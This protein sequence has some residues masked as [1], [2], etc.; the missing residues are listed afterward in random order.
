M[1]A[2]GPITRLAFS[3]LK[4]RHEPAAIILQALGWRNPTHLVHC[5]LH[6]TALSLGPVPSDPRA[7][8][9]VLEAKAALAQSE[10]AFALAQEMGRWPADL[11]ARAAIAL[12]RL[13]LSVP[14]DVAG[15]L[16]DN[17][18]LAT[19]L[20]IGEMPPGSTPE[21][22]DGDSAFLTAA[23]SA[24]RGDHRA[25]RRAC[26]AGFAAF[27]LRPMVDEESCAPLGLASF[28]A[29]RSSLT[30]DGPLVSVIVAARDAAATVAPA[31]KSLLRQ[32]W[33]NLEVV[34]V[35]DCSTD[36]TIGCAREAAACDPRLTIARLAAPSGPYAARN[37]GM[38][39]ARGAFISFSD[40]DDVAHADRIALQVA[41]L[42]DGGKSASVSR[43]VRLDECGRPVA[44]RVWPFV[45][46]S[47]SSLFL[48]ASLAKITGPFHENIL[49]A[50]GEY[51]A[52]L[53][54]V[55][56][57][58]SIAWLP[59]PVTIASQRHNSLTGAARTGLSTA[60]GAGRR[61]AHVEDWV[62]DH[63]H[64]LAA[65]SRRH[66]LLSLPMG[67]PPLSSL[68]LGFLDAEQCRGKAIWT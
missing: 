39:M 66:S 53:S 6:H 45:R 3:L 16:P 8:C 50:D 59:F 58:A 31:I 60:E 1:P 30:F 18:R 11:K 22:L 48:S 61:T 38:R 67:P 19:A 44:P 57:T 55:A 4:Q 13:G 49:G 21:P 29:E 17:L 15:T 26:N 33:H 52:R 34:L 35:D 28:L 25:A 7:L 24:G 51:L 65:A 32:S 43:L 62:R 20:A 14:T 68:S 27:G 12:A 46:L 56:G 10:G 42:L 9:A 40:S 5:G 64:Q 36:D 63:A 37:I 54:L 23:V 41:P 2:T 47:V